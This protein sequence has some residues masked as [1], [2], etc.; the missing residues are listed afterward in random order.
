MALHVERV[1][2]EHERSHRGERGGDLGRI[3]RPGALAPA[4]QAIVG[5]QLDDN[6][7]H[8]VATSELTS[9]WV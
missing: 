4:D 3:G 6:V 9:A 8:A 1:A 5:D 2:A 7:G